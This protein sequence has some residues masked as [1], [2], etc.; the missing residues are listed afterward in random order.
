MAGYNPILGNRARETTSTTGTGTYSLD[1][2]IA[3][4]QS[5]VAACGTGAQA[6]L[7]VANASDWELLLG[8]ITDASPDTVSRDIIL[9]SSNSGAAVSWPAGTKNV[10]VLP[11]AE[12][13]NHLLRR[14]V[15]ELTADSDRTL[16]ATEYFSR[17]LRITD[18]PVTL[19]AARNIVLPAYQ[20]VWFVEN[21]TARTL[22]FKTASGTGVAVIAGATAI[23]AGDGT[24][25]TALFNAPVAGGFGT[26]AAAT[27]GTGPSQVPTNA[28]IAP[29]IGTGL[30]SENLV[31][32]NGATATTQV[33]V[34]ADSLLVY[35]TAGLPKLLTAVS[36][37]AD[38]TLAG[39]SG[40]DTGAE[41]ASTW[42]YPWVVSRASPLSAVSVTADASTDRITSVA[43]GMVANTPVKF[44]GGGAPAGLT[45]GTTYYIRDVLTDTFKV[46]ATPA[47]AAI[48]L[49]TAGTTVTLTEMAAVVL[50]ASST[51]PTMPSGYTFRQRVGAARN[52][53]SSNLLLL[54][55]RRGSFRYGELV[56][57]KDGSFTTGS[58]TAQS[59]TDFFPPT[60]RSVVCLMGAN[61]SSAM[62]ISDRSDGFGATVSLQSSSGNGSTNISGMLPTARVIANWFTCLYASTLYYRTT[63]AA[64][65]WVAVGWE[66]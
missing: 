4:H 27:L 16:T 31:V 18:S 7:L 17:T 41:G 23:L 55:N 5:I 3:G 22:T 30:A 28:D 62:G 32:T 43:H 65:S 49:T 12:I 24:N 2:P 56:T 59:V 53:A 50:S 46:A 14:T 47:G 10:A 20:W 26:A 61:S 60:A 13:Y 57:I 52:N 33:L 38:I 66:E 15:I 29:N 19:T 44:G 45:L 25:I 11:S 35:D 34:T 39:V 36:A 21:A 37:A 40:L 51:S 58:F 6:L 1:G 48:D 42:Y 54:K 9:G 63:D 8:T 64:T